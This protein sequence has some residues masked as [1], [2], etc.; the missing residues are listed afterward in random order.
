MSNYVEET[1]V[2]GE[3]ILYQAKTSFWSQLGLI[4]G[5]SYFYSLSDLVC[6]YGLWPSSD[7]KLLNCRLPIDE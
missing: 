7:T 4:V 5:G 1:L 6:F 3:T 2:S